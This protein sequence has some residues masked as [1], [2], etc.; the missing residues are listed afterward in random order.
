MQNVLLVHQVI[1][2]DGRTEIENLLAA[3]QKI[4]NAPS[5]RPPSFDRALRVFKVLIAS[6]RTRFPLSSLMTT[7]GKG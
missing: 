3:I 5:H 7:V 1:V 6:A 4:Q 2:P